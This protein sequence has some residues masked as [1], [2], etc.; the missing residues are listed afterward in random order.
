MLSAL[1]QTFASGGFL[2]HG[3]CYLWKP[4]L[5]WLHVASDVLIGVSYVAI[6]VTLAYLV[7][8]IRDIPFNWMFLAFGLFII[9]CGV[10]HFMEV[11]T[12]WTPTYWLAGDLKA[13]TAF[14]SVATALLLPPLVPRAIDLMRDARLAEARRI[15]LE[16]AKPRAC[17]ALHQGQ[18]PRQPQDPVLRQRQPRAAHPA[19]ARARADREAARLARAR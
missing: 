17:R 14:A 15:R 18:G 2:P 3:H 1:K 10:T 9:A 6:S 8:R 5:V 16:T 12:L 19:R 11:W 13:L 7:K 4:A